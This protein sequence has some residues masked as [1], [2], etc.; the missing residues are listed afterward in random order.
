MF[1]DTA[2]KGQQRQCHYS[3]QSQL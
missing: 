3:S 1:I 2:Q